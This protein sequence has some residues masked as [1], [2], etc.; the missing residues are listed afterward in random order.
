MVHE[1]HLQILVIVASVVSCCFS[2]VVIITMLFFR[3]M[4]KGNFM[5][6]I[7]FMSL[8]D[9][10]MNSTSLLGFPSDGSALCWIQGVLQSYFAVC[11]WFWT[12]IL[13]Y[14]VYSIVSFGQC[15]LTMTQMHVF[16]W[17]FPMFLALI[18]ITTNNYGS[19]AFDT[20]WCV[21][22]RRED[23][24]PW[25]TLFWSYIAFFLWLFLCIVLMIFWQIRISYKFRDSPMKAVVKRTYDKVYLYPVVMVVC[26][27][28]NYW[29]DA[30]DAHG[31]GESLNAL[32]MLFGI[33]NGIFSAMIFMFK[34]EEA[35][36]RWKV[37]FYPPK[38]SNFDDFVEPPIQLDFEDD[39]ETGT[40]FT[41]NTAYTEKTSISNASE[42]DMTDFTPANK[43][44]LHI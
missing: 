22:T 44:P 13:A 32:S 30:L 34:S 1:T 25:L 2:L 6:I 36:R 19:S 38:Q 5:P 18:P 39:Y 40:N 21:L 14:R 10:G 17:V 23:N 31:A 3:N 12:T 9:L 28:L 11:S 4:Q 33:S 26:W 15:S 16:A 27:V 35:R 29:C 42:L 20:Q 43:N 8:S 24:P 7:F 37:Y 41:S